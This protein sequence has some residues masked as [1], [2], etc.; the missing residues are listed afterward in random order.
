MK[1]AQNENTSATR[2]TRCRPAPGKA[3]LLC[4]D[5]L[6]LCGEVGLG[7]SRRCGSLGDAVR[8]AERSRRQREYKALAPPL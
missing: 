1:P 8:N 2:S 4:S 6:D 5:L 7:A 3:L